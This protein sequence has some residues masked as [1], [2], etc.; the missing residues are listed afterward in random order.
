MIF[1]KNIGI[2]NF[3]KILH[4]KIWTDR[5]NSHCIC[6]AVVA[7]VVKISPAN[8]GDIRDSGSIPGP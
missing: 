3:R 2:Y 4:R 7:L 6:Q 8:E 1:L 5:K